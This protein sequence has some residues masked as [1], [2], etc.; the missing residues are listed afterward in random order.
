MKIK[1][2]NEELMAVKLSAGKTL[3]VLNEHKLRLSEQ[4]ADTKA[5]IEARADKKGQLQKIELENT[6]LSK[7]LLQERK[8]RN[9]L[10]QQVE[11]SSDLPNIGDYIEQKRAMYAMESSLKN[12]RK[13]LEILEMAARQSHKIA[14]KAKLE[15][16]V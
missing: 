4:M 8:Q 14:A 3:R 6:V 2:R 5:L 9:Q 10:R 15:R 11:E 16:T 1:E 13:K 12:W 7:D